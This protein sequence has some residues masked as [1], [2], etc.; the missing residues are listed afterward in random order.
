MVIK[1]TIPTAVGC[2]SQ[3]VSKDLPLELYYSEKSLLFFSSHN[4]GCLK[5]SS[6]T[7]YHSL[8]SQ[9]I[10][11]T[12]SLSVAFPLLL[13]KVLYN[14]DGSDRRPG[15]VFAIRTE[16]FMPPV[17]EWAFRVGTLCRCQKASTKHGSFGSPL[18]TQLTPTVVRRWSLSFP[19]FK[20]KKWGLRKCKVGEQKTDRGGKE[21]AGNVLEII[22]KLAFGLWLFELMITKVSSIGAQKT[23]EMTQVFIFR[24]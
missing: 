18:R 3:N 24:M 9:H 17:T 7:Y 13:P 6:V 2:K 16:L 11:H 10:L 8:F 5:Y 12:L 1:H 4:R 21:G 15:S 23:V 22:S 20:E 14:D 19:F